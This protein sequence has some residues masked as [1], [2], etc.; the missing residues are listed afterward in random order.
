MIRFRVRPDGLRAYYLAYPVLEALR[1]PMT[2][3]NLEAPE[4]SKAG[5]AG[6]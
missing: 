1:V 6:H 4:E 2:R 5:G 3:E